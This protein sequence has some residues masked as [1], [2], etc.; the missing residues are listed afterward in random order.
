[1]QDKLL[2]QYVQGKRIYFVTDSTCCWSPALTHIG[3]AHILTDHM[4]MDR[5]CHMA[6][7]Y[8]ILFFQ[9]A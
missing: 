8:L 7:A 6:D 4:D 5:T 9:A 2:Q 3:V 1:M